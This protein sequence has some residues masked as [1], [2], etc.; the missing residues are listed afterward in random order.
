M[1]LIWEGKV[2]S[3]LAAA[4]ERIKTIECPTG[5]VEYR[6]ADILDDYGIANRNEIIINRDKSL[7]RNGAQAYCTNPMENM[8]KSIVILA[9]SGLDDYVAKVEDAYIK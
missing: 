3:R 6:V 7:D 4:V 8:G 9:K 5:E 1:Y 2:M